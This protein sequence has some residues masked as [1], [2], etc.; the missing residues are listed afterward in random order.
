MSAADDEWM[1]QNTGMPRALAKTGVAV[2]FELCLRE[3]DVPFEIRRLL[4]HHCWPM[5]QR[6]GGQRT[7][8]HRGVYQ[9]GISE[10][11]WRDGHLHGIHRKFYLTGMTMT[12]LVDGRFCGPHYQRVQHG[13]LC[14]VGTR[15]NDGP[16]I[17][18][19]FQQGGY[20]LNCITPRLKSEKH[21][22][23]MRVMY[24]GMSYVTYCDDV[25][26]GPA[27][28]RFWDYTR[29]GMYV[30]G[31]RDGVWKGYYHDGTLESQG[32]Y[33]GGGLVGLHVCY[34]S[35]GTVERAHLYDTHAPDRLLR[36]FYVEDG[37]VTKFICDDPR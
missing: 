31:W 29:Y 30:D 1:L 15:D 23:Q 9:D 13:M 25:K 28:L 5:N 22:V 26:S 6:I 12:T 35:D 27:A 19:E 16:G 11:E 2:A 7:G 33:V 3:R 18:V 4:Q 20:T 17:S 37:R 14:E 21:G 10:G 34:K 24:G 32:T 36:W 8:F